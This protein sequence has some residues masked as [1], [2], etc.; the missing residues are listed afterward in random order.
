MGRIATDL[1]SAWKG[2]VGGKWASLV[3][4]L[5]LAVGTGASA[6]AAAV[7]YG[8]LLKPLPL[9]D[10]AQLITINREF[11]RTGLSSGFLVSEF[12]DFRAR[13]GD[14]MAVA[15][16]AGEST[17]LRSAGEP[18]AIRAAY[19]LGDWFGV[20]GARAAAGRLFDDTSDASNA[21]VSAELAA[22]V[23][24]G[25]LAAVIGRSIAIGDRS[26]QVIGVLP[27]SFAVIDDADVW[28][29]ARGARGLALF[30]ATDSRNYSVIARVT[31]GTP[32]AAA[33][34]SADAAIKAMAPEAQRGNWRLTS[35]T[36][37]ERLLGDARPVLLALLLAS[38]LVLCVACANVAMLLVNRAVARAREFSLR[39]ALGASRGRLLMVATL[40]TAMLAV[41]GGA[42]GGWLA[43]VASRTLATETGLALPGVATAVGNLSLAAGV[44]AATLFVLAVCGA[45]PLL[46]LREST[47]AMA[48][49]TSTIAGSRAGRRV[50]GALVVAQLAMTVVLATGAGLLGRTLLAVSRQDVGLDATERV[51]TLNVPI[52]QSAGDAAARLSVVQRLIDGTRRL[53]G[54]TA[55][56][57]GAALPPSVGSMVFSIRVLNETTGVDEIRAFDMVPVTDG[58]LEALGARLISGR[59]FQPSD[60]L[61]GAPSVVVMSESA[62]KHLAMAVDTA[63]GRELNMTLP[64]ASGQRV[65]PRI[66]G[67]VKDVRY[68]GLDTPAH[69][70]IYVRWTQLPFVN[71]YLVARTTGDP[72]ALAASMTT[73]AREVD[74]SIP[75]GS[76]VTFSDVVD[77]ALA[78]RTARFGLVGTLAIGAALLGVIGLTGALVRSVIERQR[79]L[80]I[81]S[82]IGAT[83]GRLLGDVL[84]HGAWLGAGG[85]A[86]GLAASLAFARAA[87]T[88]LFGVTPYDPLTYT[89]TAVT[90]LAIALL[91]SY[92]P[93]RRAAAADPIVLLR[94]E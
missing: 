78:P 51:L 21:V 41:A 50:R 8:G 94:S 34:A 70:G 33:R 68:S 82:A 3:A 10:D 2:V 35:R 37:R 27:A 59:P 44:G 87:A 43:V 62:L 6:T 48:L 24:P 54:V 5:A 79:E 16:Y 55:A 42:A 69:G 80:A 64:S 81:R 66:V 38:A 46:T 74:P 9:P 89:A 58:Y 1:R 17:T 61:P 20:L 75:L 45:A 4:V 91:A 14:E 90:V 86:L 76:A 88:L 65:R 39:L 72:A 7:A 25:D 67:V 28:I 29:P 77:E 11:A 52:A 83:P 12:D 85:L 57:F 63:L 30:G 19:V 31:E 40:E 53:P 71:A 93:A 92:L 49:R 13:I 22:R 18:Q 60:A 36:L 15:A 73:L 84:R 47:M 56:G 26:L 32:V 23:Q